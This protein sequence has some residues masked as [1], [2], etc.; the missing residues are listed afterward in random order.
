MEICYLQSEINQTSLFDDVEKSY[1]SH[2][3]ESFTEEEQYYIDRVEFAR[4]K[5]ENLRSVS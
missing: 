1:I 3:R 5:I 2:A 4:K